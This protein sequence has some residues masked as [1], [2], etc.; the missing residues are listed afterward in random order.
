VKRREFI[1]LLGGV[2]AAWPLAARAQQAGDA[3]DRISASTAA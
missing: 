2:A 3:G 1:S